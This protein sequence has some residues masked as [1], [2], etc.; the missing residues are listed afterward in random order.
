MGVTYAG[1][2]RLKA[3]RVGSPN[4]G[5]IMKISDSSVCHL[6]IPKQAEVVQNWCPGSGQIGVRLFG[7]AWRRGKGTNTWNTDIVWK[8]P[9]GWDG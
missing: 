8:G 3:R 6:C 9:Y 2:V 4:C 1:H 7:G 5:G